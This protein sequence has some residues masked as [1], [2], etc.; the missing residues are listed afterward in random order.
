MK[1]SAAV[2]DLSTVH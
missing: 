1:L 2:Y